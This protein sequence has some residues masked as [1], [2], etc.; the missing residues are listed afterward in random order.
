MT[1]PHALV[2]KT[3]V[4][5]GGG[6]FLGAHLCPGLLDAGAHVRA[7][8][9][10]RYHE[11]PLRGVQWLGGALSDLEKLSTVVEGA[12]V[13]FHLA[14]SSTPASAEAGRIR[15]LTTSVAGTIDLL[16]LCRNAGVDR[17]VFTSSG[18]TVYGAG[19]TPPF[20]ERSLPRPMST[21]GINKLAIEG[22]MSLYNRLYGMRNVS[23]R[24]A[25]PFGPYQHGLKNQGV[26]SV[27]AQRALAGEPIVIWG[28][29]SAERDYLFAPD[30]AD[31]MLRAAVYDGD[32]EVFNVGSGIGRSLREVVV[33]LEDVL[34]RSIKV[35]YQ[36]KRG[37]DVPVSVLDSRLA[38]RELGWQASTDWADALR[39]TCDWLQRRGPVSP[40]S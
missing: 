8:G 12:D 25:N 1:A 19:E 39:L 23:L 11:E 28:D 31:A 30:V 17:V 2:G 16:D 20:T 24:I 9:R 3:C 10:T 35:E 13:V 34:Q 18:G 21:Y 7:Y 26:V 22:Y 37:F 27:F 36:R 33:S 15:D 4:V 38:Q 32:E 29:G 40:Q 5:I 14:G 6:G